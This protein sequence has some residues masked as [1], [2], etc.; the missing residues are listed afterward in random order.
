MTQK[1][2]N[3]KWAEFLI[4]DLFEIE[5]TLSFNK[6]LLTE[7]ATYD[8]VTRTS[9]NQGILQETGF[10]NSENINSAGN[11][12]L[13]LLQMDFFYRNKPWYAGQF[14]RKITPKIK[15]DNKK[16]ILFFTVLL[17]KHKSK[18]LSVLVRD[19]DDTF[20]NSKITLPTKDGAIDFA[21]MEDF[22]SEIEKQPLTALENYLTVTG[23][24][25]YNLTKEEEETLNSL[26]KVEW[27]EYRFADIFNNIQQGRRL[28]KDDQ[29]EGSI[30][31]VMAGV[32]NT[33]VV[34]YISNPVAT[35]PKNS[36]T[37]DI[38]GNAFYR[39]YDFGAGDDTGVYWNTER[40]LSREMML[41]LTK[42]SEKALQG[43][44]SYGKKLRSSQSLNFRMKLPTK[45]GTPDYD[46]MN[47]YIKAIHKVVI[48]E[49]VLY[50]EKK[51]QATQEV[52]NNSSNP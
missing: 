47:T 33:G 17:N 3:V 24:K 48:K 1:L 50:A 2:Q 10:V 31:F 32:T 12:S 51:I 20:R 44:F 29:I 42:T 38:F 16:V 11:W 46:F 15:L 35:F 36:I 21:F 45:N 34:N 19:V 4:G 14:V 22:I 27:K 23:L 28:K 52:V 25:N 39:N 13:G 49:V 37:I 5:N 30:P 18:L 9:Q 8:Y 43:K 6:E 41:F 26:D 40:K 7:G